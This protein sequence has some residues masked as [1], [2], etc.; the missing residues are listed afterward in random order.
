MPEKTQAL[1]CDETSERIV[2]TAERLATEE[3]ASGITVRRILQEMGVSNRVFY[4]RFHNIDEVLAIVYRNTVVKIRESITSSLDAE[5]DFFEFVT[6]MVVAALLKSYDKKMQFNDY[7]FA[8]DSASG[9]NCEWWTAE[10]KKLLEYAKQKGYIK[11]VDSDVVSY[12]VWCFCRGFNADAV[13]RNLPKDDAVAACR[14][15]FGLLLD[16]LRASAE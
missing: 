14:Y 16:G 10:I 2:Q 6:D 3:G 8:S 5:K 11:N 9:S 12:T 13:S 4:N 15:G 7:F 1:I